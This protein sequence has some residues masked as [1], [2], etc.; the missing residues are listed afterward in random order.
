MGGLTIKSQYIFRQL[1]WK[2]I[3]LLCI[4]GD[5]HVISSET[6]AADHLKYQN[7]C[8]KPVTS[9]LLSLTLHQIKMKDNKM[10]K[11]EINISYDFGQYLSTRLLRMVRI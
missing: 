8:H 11:T 2:L 6:Q 9:V 4:A 10:L 7:V 1:L 3:F 5:E